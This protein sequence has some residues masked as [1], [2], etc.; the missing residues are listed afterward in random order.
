MESQKYLLQNYYTYAFWCIIVNM[1]VGFA[2]M[3]EDASYL[4]LIIGSIFSGL[5]VGLLFTVLYNKLRGI[6]FIGNKYVLF[7]ISVVL[8]NIILSIL[9]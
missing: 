4:F 3:A 1:V 7:I 9:F 6:D 5:M 8:Y 2:T